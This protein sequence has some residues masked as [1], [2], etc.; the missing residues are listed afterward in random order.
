MSVQA[1][2]FRVLTEFRFDIGHAV[3]ESHALQGEIGKISAAADQALIGFKRIGM[4][5]VAQAGLGSG[6]VLAFLYN[7]I[8]ASDK[9]A[10]SQRNLANILLSNQDVLGTG[11]MSFEQAMVRSASVMD[12]IIHKANEFALDP[13][14]LL[15][16]TKA[17]APM[18]ISH[19]LD[20]AQMQ[21]SIDIARG[22]LKS[23]PTL[24]IDPSMI[25]SQ[26]VSLV[27]GRADMNNTLFQR[28]L[29]ET[30]PFKDAKVNDSKGF[31][32]L[33]AHKRIELL[34]SSLLQ[35]GSN[36]DV[37]RGNMESL[38]GQFQ[39]FQ[40]LVKGQFSIFKK[41]GD[42]LMPPLKMMLGEV[43]KFLNTEGRKIAEH[44]SKIIGD[45]VKDPIKF[46]INLRQLSRLQGDV[47]NAGKLLGFLG[48]LE[49]TAFAMRFLGITIRG[50]SVTSGIKLLG[51]GL[52]WIGGLF[53]RLGGFALIFRALAFVATKILAPLMALTFLFQIISR[54][55][56]KA[57]I[58]NAKWLVDHMSKLTSLFGRIKDAIAKI[59]MPIEMAIDF[60]SDLVAWFFE[61]DISGNIL[62]SIFE[63]LA[64]A[65]EAIGFIVVSS[66]SIISGAIASIL[67]V[68]MD[69]KNLEFSGMGKRI[70]LAFNEGFS[71]FFSKHYDR[72]GGQ[73]GSEGDK[74][75]NRI[76]NIGKVEINNQ[77]KEQLEPD[78][79][80]F[81]L[82]EQIL[83][84]ALNPQQ[85]AGRSMRGMAIGR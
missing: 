7:A 85:A 73:N 62:I 48:L 30:K 16:Q 4:S 33:D 41:V 47:T 71:D 35:F 68:I 14:E 56:A 19:G 5:L 70:G 36:A 29:A 37:L 12:T 75:S 13:N 23:A 79:I 60:W 8:T 2:A 59:F 66:M 43:N 65:L 10:Q 67:Q 45:I 26:L 18:L 53:V 54:A 17:V 52:L 40:N 49:A 22:L 38:S 57:E 76:T 24:A 32:S 27:T 20:T 55:I 44:L 72:S 46:F 34:R 61:L 74:V 11:G 81:T 58:S 21:T 50:A 31:N 69:A 42:A 1:Q 84:A 63:G 64:N 80:A 39:V 15:N 77:F 78:R 3:A 51:Q 28:L 83:K 82:K 9:F 6:G 25:G